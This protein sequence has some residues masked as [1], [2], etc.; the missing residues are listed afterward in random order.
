VAALAAGQTTNVSGL[1]RDAGVSRETVRGYF[2]VLVDTLIGRWLPAY[3]PRAKVKEVAHPKFYWFD[4]GVLN[5][6]A[7]AFDQPPPGDWQG[8]LFEH[9]VHRE[10]RSFIDCHAIKGSLGYWRTP[11]FSEVDFVWWRG[12][13]IVAV[14]VKHGT[15]FSR[16]WHKGLASLVTSSGGISNVSTYIV[17]RGLR[18]L[19]VENTRVMPIE[20]FLRELYQGDIIS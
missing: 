20:A 2:D 15:D 1:A 9:L 5:A 4:T 7:G 18:E 16:D 19:R 8:V 10:L 12:E 13:R 14:E 6:A 17:Y 11:S 3:R